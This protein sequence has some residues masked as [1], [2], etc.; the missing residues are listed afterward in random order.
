MNY[1]TLVTTKY[2]APTDTKG[3]R[4]KV[5]VYGYGSQFYP[6]EHSESSAHF[7]AAREFVNARPELKRDMSFKGEGYIGNGVNVY[8]LH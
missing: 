2:Y 8:I 1:Y 4:I 5:S 3:A 7:A 6:Y